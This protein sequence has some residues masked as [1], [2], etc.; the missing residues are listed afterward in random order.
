[1]HQLL[2]HGTESNQSNQGDA[3][4][5]STVALSP[6]WLMHPALSQQHHPA[7]YVGMHQ[8]K[9]CIVLSEMLVTKHARSALS[10]ALLL[11]CRY[12]GE[13]AGRQRAMPHIKTYVRYRGQQLAWVLL[14]S[15]NLSKAAWG[16]LQKQV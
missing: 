12:G 1:M 5:C 8:T 9:F 6:H 13:V 16:S 10:L 7:H 11:L 4:C 15:H 14:A 3:L 2:L